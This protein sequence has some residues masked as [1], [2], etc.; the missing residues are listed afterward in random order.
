MYKQRQT[1]QSMRYTNKTKYH[2]NNKKNTHKTQNNTIQWHIKTHIKSFFT[3]ISLKHYLSNRK[4]SVHFS[5]C[6]PSLLFLLAIIYS[7]LLSLYLKLRNKLGFVSSLLLNRVYLKIN[8]IV[9]V[10]LFFTLAGRIP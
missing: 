6:S 1:R 3:L 5:K 2:N 9:L 8:I 10:K 7:T 4:I